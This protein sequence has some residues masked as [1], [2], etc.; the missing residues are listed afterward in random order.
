MSGSFRKQRALSCDDGSAFLHPEVRLLQE[1]RAL[2]SSL[3]LL[4]Q[5]CRDPGLVQLLEAQDC[6]ADA[7]G[8]NGGFGHSYGLAPKANGFAGKAQ[9]APSAGMKSWRSEVLHLDR[10][11]F[12]DEADPEDSDSV[13]TRGGGGLDAKFHFRDNDYINLR[14]LGGQTFGSLQSSLA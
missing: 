9:T 2:S 14:P 4:T 13:L 5:L 7:G 1:N 12:D 8:A 10:L 3:P 6:G 11:Q